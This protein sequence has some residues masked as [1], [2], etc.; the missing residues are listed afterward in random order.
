M[1]F[2]LLKFL[3]RKLLSYFHFVSGYISL[4]H[5]NDFTNFSDQWIFF[6]EHVLW[7]SSTRRLVRETEAEIASR[8]NCLS[9]TAL[10]LLFFNTCNTF[11]SSLEQQHTCCYLRP[12]LNLTQALVEFHSNTPVHLPQNVAALLLVKF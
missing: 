9:R 6:Y 8:E 12:T 2:N 10:I 1:R 11:T 3:P 5:Q 7:I 4:L